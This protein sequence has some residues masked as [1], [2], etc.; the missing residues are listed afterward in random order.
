M[1]GGMT[2][3]DLRIAMMLAVGVVVVG[4]GIG[5][6]VGTLTRNDATVTP[7]PGDAHSGFATDLQAEGYPQPGGGV[8]PGYRDV[9]VNDYQDLLDDAAE[10]RIRAELIE[11]FDRTGI[12]MTVLTIQ[13]VAMFGTHQQIEPFATALFNAWGIGN[14]TRNDGVLILISRFDREM[15]IEIGSGYD[16]S[17]DARMKRVIDT[18]FIPSFR[19][20]DYQGGIEAGVAATIFELT[21]SYPGEQ[22]SGT[23]ARGWSAIWRT[24]ERV[25]EWALLVLVAPLGGAVL[26]VRRYLRRRPRPCPTCATLMLR[27]GEK[28]D[29]EHLD[30]GQRLEEFLQSVDYDVWHCPD[31]GDMQINR[32]ASWF[33]SHGACP[34]CGYRT[35]ASHSTILVAATKSSSGKKRVDYNCQH[36]KHHYSE[37]RTIPKISDSNSSGSSRSSFGGGSSSGGGASGSW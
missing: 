21:G 19:D 27:A 13:N 2:R 11:L 12:E 28:A 24:V 3:H 22:E 14:A 6:L 10:A 9:Y 30:G 25:G 16:A 37:T 32:Y 7:A 34:E 36:C 29:D 4:L 35:L 5:Y 8:L 31:C 17:W 20:D 23:I 26:W 15:R 1:I 18:D 33:S